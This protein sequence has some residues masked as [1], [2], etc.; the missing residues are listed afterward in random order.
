MRPGFLHKSDILH[1][2]WSR[3]Y[4]DRE[5]IAVSMCP[6]ASGCMLGRDVGLVYDGLFVNAPKGR[7]HG[8]RTPRVTLVVC[9]DLIHRRRAP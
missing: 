6:V 7:E 5:R 4:R 9:G 2:T 8:H 3:L 1:E